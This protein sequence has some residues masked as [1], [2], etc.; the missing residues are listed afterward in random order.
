MNYSVVVFGA[1]DVTKLFV[2]YVN[3]NVCHVDLVVTI[4]EEIPEKIVVSSYENMDGL[5]QQGTAMF[6][7]DTYDLKSP[8]A[9]KFF[10]ENTFD[11]GISMN[12]S[13]LIPG[14]ILNRF[15]VGVFGLHGSCGYLPFGQGRATLNWSLIHGAQR[16]VMHMFRLDEGADSPD[17]YSST[18]FEINDFDDIRTLQYKDLLASMHLATKLL[19]EYK[20]GQPIKTTVREDTLRSYPGRKP[21]EG[22]VNML[23]YTK[24]I[25]NLVR[26]VTH[27]FPGAFAYV[28]EKKVTLWN[29]RPFDRILDFSPYRL[30]EVIQV[31]DGRPLV[32][33]ADGSMLVLEYEAEK[34]LEKGDI[35][36]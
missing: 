10:K 5:E 2:E 16:I 11:L 13:R 26:A 25:Y 23:N 15:S 7:A 27:P 12:W 3:Q 8:A 35:L 6:K 19:K 21:E 14:W 1:K 28:K 34:S 29:V 20:T 17:I 31:L 36:T 4:D 24:E 18:M 30:G 32:R 33:T 22:R 9:Q